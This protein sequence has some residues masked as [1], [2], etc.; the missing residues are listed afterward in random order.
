MGSAVLFV[1][2]PDKFFSRNYKRSETPKEEIEQEFT[3]LKEV[4]EK[5]ERNNRTDMRKLRK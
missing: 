3:E 5:E 2:T 4:L 1:L